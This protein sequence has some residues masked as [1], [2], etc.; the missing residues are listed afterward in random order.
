MIGRR[1]DAAVVKTDF[2]TH[3]MHIMIIKYTTLEYST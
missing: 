2:P 3:H 1:R